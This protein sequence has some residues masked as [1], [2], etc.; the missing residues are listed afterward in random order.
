MVSLHPTL[1]HYIPHCIYS[2]YLFILFPQ[3][4]FIKGEEQIHSYFH[5]LH[6]TQLVSHPPM[7]TLAMCLENQ[8]PQSNVSLDCCL[9]EMLW[10]NTTG[11]CITKGYSTKGNSFHLRAKP[12]TNKIIKKKKDNPWWKSDA[13]FTDHL[14]MGVREDDWIVPPINTTEKK[15]NLCIDLLH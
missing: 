1:L 2:S 6:L 9:L 4:S 3:T 14:V 15:A 5:I 12:E 13:C 11:R 10:A 7:K 8:G